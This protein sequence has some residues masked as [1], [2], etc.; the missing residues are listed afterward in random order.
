MIS[1]SNVVKR[2]DEKL[3]LDNI[4]W[5]LSKGHCY[6]LV[7]PNGSGKSTLLRLI[8]GVIE[9]DT[10]TVFVDRENVF[11][12]PPAK[13]KIFFLADD[14]YFF[15]QSNMDEMRAFY[16]RFYPNFDVQKYQMLLEDFKLDPFTKINSFSKGMKRQVMLILGLASNP[17][18]LLLDEAFDGLDPLM[19][20]KLRQYIAQEI[21]ENEIL[22]VISS[23]NLRELEDICDHIAMINN[24][25]LQMDSATDEMQDTYHKYQLVFKDR[26]DI[27]VL[28]AL[29]PLHVSGTDRIFTMIV[30]GDKAEIEPSLKALD[31]MI[32]E[33]GHASLE[34]IFIYE[35]E[36]K[37]HA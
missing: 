37:E 4:N 33:K 10:G 26:F 30:K 34:E 35:T 27:E 1:F 17:D 9:A 36:D 28:K 16:Q 12:N 23:H 15:P 18:I 24:N 5:K 8:S 13:E 3:V 29:N 31:P 21:S 20:F 2:F 11:D 7:G 6:G 14:P 22:V 32:L 25:K 19:R